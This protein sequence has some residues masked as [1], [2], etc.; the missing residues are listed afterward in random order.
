MKKG[1]SFQLGYTWAL[2]KD[3][4]SFDPVFTTVATGTGQAAGNTP[5]DNSNRKAN[6]AWSDFDR[7]HSL[8]GT[9][10]YELPFGKGKPFGGDSPAVLNY[11]ISGWQIAGTL[12]VTS[13]RPFTVFSGLNTLSQTAG[14]FANCSACPR[15]LGSLVQGDF[16]NPGSGLR[17][18]FF[19]AAGRNLFRQPGPGESGNTGR[20]HFIG[21]RFTETDISVLRKFR[22]TERLAFDL[23]V[24][25]R[26]LTNTPNFAAPSAVLP[27]G[28]AQSGNVFGTSIFG[29]IN[30]DTTNNNRRIQFSG[31][32]SF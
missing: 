21:P 20:N 16:D 7:R 5:F 8:L 27:A 30:A 9:Y 13:G 26:N 6:Y 25:V 32:L 31:K 18:W 28:L 29:R 1:L 22:F 15:N 12:R 3:S 11:I 14:S 4:R 17:N 24:D 10:V 2:S 19:D 23:R